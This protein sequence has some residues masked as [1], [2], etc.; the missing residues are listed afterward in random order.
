MF[1]LPMWRLSTVRRKLFEFFG[2]KRYSNPAY[3]TL[4]E[5]LSSHLNSPGFF[6]EAGAVDGVF[7]SN[8][9]YLER[10]QNWRGILVEPVPEMF[11]RI[12]V[13]RPRAIAF[14]CALVS[15]EQ[16]CSHVQI[17]SE[18]AMSHVILPEANGAQSTTESTW[19]H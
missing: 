15:D 6:V 13:N 16:A 14:Q 8:T 18:H 10:F 5:E 2:N 7:E 19:F 17:V 9:Y 12:R 3:G 11:R 4:Q 1:K